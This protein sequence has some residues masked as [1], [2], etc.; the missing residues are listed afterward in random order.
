MRKLRD[1]LTLHNI[2]GY[3]LDA[4]FITVFVHMAMLPIWIER[5]KRFPT[6]NEIEKGYY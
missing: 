5:S 6:R 3:M 2:R 4:L 1:R